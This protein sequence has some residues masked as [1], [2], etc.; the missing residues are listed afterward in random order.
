MEKLTLKQLNVYHKRVLLRVDFNVPLTKR[1]TIVDDTRIQSALPSIRSILKDQGKL[2]ILSHLGRPKGEKDLALSLAPCAKRLGELLGQTIHF[3]PDCIGQE[4][5]KRVNLLKPC[6]AVVL[7]NL[8]FH[9]EE[10]TPDPKRAFAG[11][12]A[13]LG[14]V[15]VN[16]AFGTAHRKHSSITVIT[17]FFPKKCAMGR[18]MERELSVLS[19]LMS[20]PKS[21]FSLILGGAKLGTKIGLLETLLPKI[22]ALFI[23]GGMVFTFL[24][25]QGLAIGES[26]CDQAL[27]SKALAIMKSCYHNNLALHLPTDIV[28][29]KKTASRWETDVIEVKEGIPSGWQ[30]MDIGPKTVEQWKSALLDS[31]TLFWNGPMG[32]CEIPSFAAGTAAIAKT[33][34][35]INGTSVVGGGD[36]IAAIK[37]LKLEGYFTHLSTGGGALLAYLEHG[38]LPGIDA[39]SST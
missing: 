8:R 31:A 27:L 13:K 4:A 29:G 17:H 23:G 38:H 21:P 2:V 33:L 39:L 34:G 35:G 30:G 19:D 36:S 6:E 20:H 32:V 24:K 14:D 5:L 25:A 12:L 28:I 26:I 22:D 16:D 3:A 15:Y 37:G 18:L 9:P 7:E 11:K 10:E 1:G